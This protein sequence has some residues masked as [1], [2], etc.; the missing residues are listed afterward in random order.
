M[1][2][3]IVLIDDDPSMRLLLQETLTLTGHD[4]ES[5]ASGPEAIDGAAWHSAATLVVDWMMPGMSGV[6]VAR[7]AQATHPAVHRVIV[8]AAPEALQD[9]M[10][11]MGDLA[12]VVAKADLPGGML[13]ALP[14]GG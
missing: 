10:P 3:T 2:T 14:A 5:F 4:V 1:R 12:V 11:D 9:A 6:E 8:T 13:D 7:W